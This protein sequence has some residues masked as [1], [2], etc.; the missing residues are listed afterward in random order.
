MKILITENQLDKVIDNFI[1]REIGEI[2]LSHKAMPMQWVSK[3]NH[4]SKLHYMQQSKTLWVRDE[5]WN[6][7]K[8]IFNFND[9]RTGNCIKQ[10]SQ[11]HLQIRPNIARSMGE[12]L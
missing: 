1:T 4:L 7:V 5:I 9:A 8:K 11:K 10:W 6:N 12:K 2:Y 3:K